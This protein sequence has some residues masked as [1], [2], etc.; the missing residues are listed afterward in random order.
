MTSVSEG[1]HEYCFFVDGKHFVSPD[2]PR[3]EDMTCNWRT[4]SRPTEDVGKR[5]FAQSLRLAFPD[6]P[7]DKVR[8]QLRRYSSEVLRQVLYGEDVDD[9]EAS[10]YK[11][12]G[13]SSLWVTLRPAIIFNAAMVSYFAVYFFARGTILQGTF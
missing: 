3:S 6:L 1:Y 12:D 7:V 9:L 13:K 5:T 10:K 11:L 8:S 4:V 2:H